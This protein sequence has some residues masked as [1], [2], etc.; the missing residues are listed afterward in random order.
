MDNKRDDKLKH[1][2]PG[3][4]KPAVRAGDKKRKLVAIKI[5]QAGSFG[6]VLRVKD[7]DMGHHGTAPA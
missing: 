7:G 6:M 5:I 3:E 4:V 2:T 1:Y